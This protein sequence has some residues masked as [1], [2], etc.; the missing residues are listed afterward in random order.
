MR[1]TYTESKD[2]SES[3]I[4]RWA[5][6]YFMDPLLVISATESD[7]NSKYHTHWIFLPTTVFQQCIIIKSYSHIYY[8]YKWI[9]E[10]QIYEHKSDDICWVKN[11]L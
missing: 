3:A 11:E 8:A 2:Y 4:H 1:D 5:S 9:Y 10:S 6:T 7:S